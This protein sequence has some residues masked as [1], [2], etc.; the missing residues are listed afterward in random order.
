MEPSEALESS[1]P[2]YKAG[3]SPSMLAPANCWCASAGLW[4]SHFPL[5]MLHN[6]QR[7]TGVDLMFTVVSAYALH[8]HGWRLPFILDS[9][10]RTVE[11]SYISIFNRQTSWF[12][13][14]LC[15]VGCFTQS[16][17]DSYSP[18]R[19]LKLIVVIHPIV[20]RELVDHIMIRHDRLFPPSPAGKDFDRDDDLVLKNIGRTLMHYFYFTLTVQDY[21]HVYSGSEYLCSR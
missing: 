2:A 16:H 4:R 18:H 21:V 15:G 13:L 12:R 19:S 6:T 20:I 11:P 3:A 10:A 14:R 5:W 7:V 8:Q 1:S 17:W 9:Y